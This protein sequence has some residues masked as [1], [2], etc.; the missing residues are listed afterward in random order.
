MGIRYE[1]DTIL[2]W[3]NE[4]G[5]FLRLLVDKW[6]GQ[7]VDIEIEPAYFDF[8]NKSREE[9]LKLDDEELILFVKSLDPDQIRPLAQLMMY[10]GLIN[11][12]KLLLQK[13]KSLFEFYMK[14]TGSFSFEDFGSL[15]QIDKVLK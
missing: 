9:L 7:L 2:N 12:D 15:A 11:D 5:K 3:I 4:M 14:S 13:S 8:F 1:K 6:E 10:D